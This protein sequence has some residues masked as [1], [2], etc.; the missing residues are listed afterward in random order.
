MESLD[1]K[2]FDAG[3]VL[4][5]FLLLVSPP[6]AASKAHLSDTHLARLV[7]AQKLLAD[8]DSRSQSEIIDE[9]NQTSFPEG[10]LQIYEAVAATYKELTQHKDIAR[11]NKK[12][13]L[14]DF[15]RLNIAYL[16]FGGEIGQGNKDL[17]ALIRQ[18]L[19]RHLPK[20]LLDN[21][22]LFYSLS[23]IFGE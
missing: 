1:K 9:L 2:L 19:Q 11:I 15:I 4:I 7:Q 5:L 21:D 13:R 14:Y 16:Q 18:T 12:K 22:Q 20:E 10:N 3:I 17:N 8:V 23:S 6:V